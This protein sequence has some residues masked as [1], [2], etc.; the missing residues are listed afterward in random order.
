[1]KLALFSLFAALSASAAPMTIVFSS[2]GSGSMNGVPF[3][4]TPFTITA[5]ADTAN[6]VTAVNG[7]LLFHT[8]AQIDLAGVGVFAF[9]GTTGTVVVN[10]IS[11]ARFTHQL[12]HTA[13]YDLSDPTLAAYNLLSSILVSR[14]TSALTQ[15]NVASVDTSGGTL[16]FAD[17]FDQPGTFSVTVDGVPPGVP[18]PGSWLM[19]ALPLGWLLARRGRRC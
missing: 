9:T 16:I 17:R 12:S 6:I 15:W 19:G 10:T 11:Q 4:L 5:Q 14:P 13:L 3:A 1:M 18:E 2:S 7:Y 8:S